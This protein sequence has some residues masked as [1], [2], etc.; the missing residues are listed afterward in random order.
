MAC[1]INVIRDIDQDPTAKRPALEDVIH[2]N[3]APITIGTLS[4]GMTSG[5][6]SVMFVIPL[7]DGRTVVAESSLRLVKVALSVLNTIP[8]ES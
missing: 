7:P 2:V 6:T 1:I 4:A 3:D 5:R 8:E